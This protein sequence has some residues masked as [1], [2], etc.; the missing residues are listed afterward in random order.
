M[1]KK[2]DKERLIKSLLM[3]ETWKPHGVR[4]VTH[5]WV[6]ANQ[7]CQALLRL[8]ELVEWSVFHEPIHVKSVRTCCDDDVGAQLEAI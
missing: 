5:V 4:Q 7:L 3:R 2:I 8:L 1:S 6:A